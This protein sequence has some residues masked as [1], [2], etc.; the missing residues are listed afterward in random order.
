MQKTFI[1]RKNTIQEQSLY[2]DGAPFSRPPPPTHTH[3]QRQ[4][5]FLYLNT[6]PISDEI[7]IPRNIVLISYHLSNKVHTNLFCTQVG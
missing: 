4:K 1:P 3:I 5:K 6:V 2:W 7:L